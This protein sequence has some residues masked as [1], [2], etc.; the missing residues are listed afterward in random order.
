MANFTKDT[1]KKIMMNEISV[2]SLLRQYPEYK[3][4]VLSELSELKNSTKTTSLIDAVMNKYTT[5]AK[6]ANS[7]II[8]S[9]YNETTLNAFIPEIIKARFAMYLLEQLSISTAAAASDKHNQAIRF[10]LWDGVILQKLLFKKGFE[11]KPVSL[12]LFNI[13]WRLVLHK[14]L[15]M[16]LVNQ[17]GIYCFYSK[18]LIKELSKLI[19]DKKCLEI[20]AGDG[21]LT[22]F[23][24]KIGVNCK[25]TD[26]YSWGQYITYPDFVE[27]A[28]AKTALNKYRP[29]VVLCSW[30]VPNNT[31]EKHVFKTSSVDLYIVIGT[32]NPRMTGDFDTYYSIKNFTMEKSETM[33]SLILPP[34]EENAVYIFRRIKE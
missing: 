9:G 8:K 27:K 29:E 16:P 25:A 33:S 6:I 23:L 11:R 15:L 34:S 1:A 31:Y 4:E 7:K 32:Q 21:T 17:K 13:L 3:D 28:D 19:G 18:A 14:K 12:R 20:A 22:A 26:D 10:N 24:N 30:P 5:N 2:E